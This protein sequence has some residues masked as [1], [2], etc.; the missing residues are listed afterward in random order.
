MFRARCV[1]RRS[2]WSR[3]FFIY[4]QN[5]T[6]WSHPGGARAVLV[7]SWPFRL[8]SLLICSFPSHPFSCVYRGHRRA[9][10]LQGAIL[11]LCREF[12]SP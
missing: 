10:D 12:L 9:A 1:A 7:P 2:S 3:P 4:R 6:G 8:R 5:E 11:F